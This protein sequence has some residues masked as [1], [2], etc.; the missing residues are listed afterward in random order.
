[1]RMGLF[2][3]KVPERR[4]RNRA[5]VPARKPWAERRSRR[6]AKHSGPGW[7]VQYEKR[8][9]RLPVG[10]TRSSGMRSWVRCY[11]LPTDAT[12]SV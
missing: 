12:A 3:E 2:A 1:M 6:G 11:L 4:G 9:C 5:Y 7:A 10:R 8:N